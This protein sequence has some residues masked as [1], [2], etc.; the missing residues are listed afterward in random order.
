MLSFLDNL[1]SAGGT[2]RSSS[3]ILVSAAVPEIAIRTWCST[4]Q[5]YEVLLVDTFLL[6]GSVRLREVSVSG[7]LTVLTYLGDLVSASV[8]ILY[9]TAEDLVSTSVSKMSSSGSLVSAT[10]SQRAI[11]C[12]T[13]QVNEVLPTAPDLNVGGPITAVCVPVKADPP[14]DLS[15]CYSRM[16]AV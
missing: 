7:G 1:V 15:V 2:I 3:Q 8:S 10:V 5:I 6:M 16:R 13:Q 14:G 4:E 9:F 11:W 12:S